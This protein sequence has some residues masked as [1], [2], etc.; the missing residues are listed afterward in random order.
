MGAAGA[1]LGGHGHG[2]G[3][4]G[5]FGTGQGLALAHQHRQP[6]GV[7]AQFGQPG[8]VLKT[9]VFIANG[10]VAHG[11]HPLF[12][13]AQFP[14]TRQR[15]GLAGGAVAALGPLHLTPRDRAPALHVLAHGVQL[16]LDLRGLGPGDG[17]RDGP[18]ARLVQQLAQAARRVGPLPA[19][20][21]GQLGWAFQ[22]RAHGVGSAAARSLAAASISS[23]RIEASRA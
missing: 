7:L 2:A 10:A 13:A 3:Q 5:Q 21:G 18:G 15:H 16:V 11:L 1:Q 19:Q 8:Q 14:G 23:Q 6:L 9:D 4:L 17:Q 12:G 20:L 22:R